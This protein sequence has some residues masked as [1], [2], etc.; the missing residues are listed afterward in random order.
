MPAHDFVSPSALKQAAF[1]GC[2]F[3]SYYFQAAFSFS[4]SS[5]KA[6][7]QAAS[8]DNAACGFL[9]G[10]ASDAETQTIRQ[11]ESADSVFRLPERMFGKTSNRSRHTVSSLRQQKTGSLKKAACLVFAVFRLLLPLVFGKGSLKTVCHPV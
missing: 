8:A 1:S 7:E 9:A 3:D 6:F 2:L 10:L 11:P 4:E 5:L